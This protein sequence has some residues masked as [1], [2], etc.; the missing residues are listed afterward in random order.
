MHDLHRALGQGV[1]EC[2]DVGL[3]KDAG[4]EDDDDALVLLGADEVPDALAE[5]ED[6]PEE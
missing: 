3:C 4:V 1:K 5:F 2:V 6:G